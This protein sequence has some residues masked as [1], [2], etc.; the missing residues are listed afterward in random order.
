MMLGYLFAC[1][2]LCVTESKSNPKHIVVVVADDLGYNDLGVRNK[3]AS[4]PRTITPTLDA[5]IGSGITLSSYHTFKIC[6]PS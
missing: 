1:L 4:G 2:L 5:L 6:S 3:H